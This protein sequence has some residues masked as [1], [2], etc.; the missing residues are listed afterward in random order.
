MGFLTKGGRVE[1]SFDLKTT[2]FDTMINYHLSQNLKL[3]Q[4]GEFNHLTNFFYK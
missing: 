4:D 3:L 1:R 2:H